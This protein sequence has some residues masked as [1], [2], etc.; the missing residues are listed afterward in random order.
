MVCVAC[1]EERRRSDAPARWKTERYDI[2]EHVSLSGERSC[3]MPTE[4]PTIHHRFG[5]M[6]EGKHVCLF[7]LE[8]L[9]T[10]NEDWWLCPDYRSHHC[11]IVFHLN[12]F[13][14]SNMKSARKTQ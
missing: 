4:Y 3:V 5:V 6:R 11:S 8:R 9:K 12:V 7:C 13:N 10:K 14:Q 2:M 1:E